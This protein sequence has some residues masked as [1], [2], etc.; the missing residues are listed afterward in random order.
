MMGFFL[1]KYMISVL[2]TFC[3]HHL[4]W[5]DLGKL[6]SR[7][8]KGRLI[9]RSFSGVHGV[10][11]THRADSTCSINVHVAG[12]RHSIILPCFSLWESLGLEFP[13]NS[14]V[15]DILQNNR[16]ILPPCV[17]GTVDHGASLEE[18]LIA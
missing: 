16:K 4:Q 14:R 11:H 15:Y 8:Q 5:C 6:S 10:V 3:Y 1:H 7:E 2:L 9:C 17:G 18:I 13:Q 12:S